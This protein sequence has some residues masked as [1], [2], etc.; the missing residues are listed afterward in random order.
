[1]D[2]FQPD[3]R[4]VQVVDQTVGAAARHTLQWRYAIKLDHLGVGASVLKW[5]CRKRAVLRARDGV[6]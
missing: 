4:E 3:P 5:S 2:V 6:S 1:M